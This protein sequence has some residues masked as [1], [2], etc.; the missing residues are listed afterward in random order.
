MNGGPEDSPTDPPWFVHYEAALN[1][2]L[3][4]K[5]RPSLIQTQA[6]H[7]WVA[8]VERFGPP[9]SGEQVADDRHLDRVPGAKLTV[10][11]LVIEDDRE[12]TVVVRSFL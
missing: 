2:L 9:S 4:R 10:H 7:E 1:A 8:S 5:P 11:Y 12:R 6:A 3:R